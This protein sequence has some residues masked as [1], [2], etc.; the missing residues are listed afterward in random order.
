M[1]TDLHPVYF[2]MRFLVTFGGVML[3]ILIMFRALRA[4]FRP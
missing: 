2:L 4:I 3:A 1:I